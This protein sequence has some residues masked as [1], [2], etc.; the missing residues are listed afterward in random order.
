M[1]GAMSLINYFLLDPNRTISF[2]SFVE[3]Y[4]EQIKALG[5]PYD[6]DIVQIQA[7]LLAR[8]DIETLQI[9]KTVEP[10]K[11]YKKIL[12]EMLRPRIGN[13]SSEVF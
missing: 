5:E 11:S 2:D 8:T 9:I 6:N 13:N 7:E 4:V 10:D 3:Q 1:S 12:E